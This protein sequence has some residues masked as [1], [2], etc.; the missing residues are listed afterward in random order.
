MSPKGLDSRR[1]HG[2]I[3]EAMNKTLAA[4]VFVG[5]AAGCAVT[6]PQNT[7]HPPKLLTD[8]ATGQAYYLYVPSKYNPL[9][10]MPVIVSCHG[11]DP[12]DVPARQIGEWKWMGEQHGCIIVCPRLSSTDGIFGSGPTDRLLADERV[13]MSILGQLQYMYNIDRRNMM[14]TGFSG[15]GFPTYFVGLRHPD[16]FS[17]VVGRACN[18]NQATLD[19]WYPDEAV[20]MPIFIYY[21]DADLGAI[22]GQSE[23]AIAY[24]RSAGFKVETQTLPGVGHQRHP[25]VAMRFFIKHWHGT[26]PKLVLP[27]NAM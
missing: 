8:P 13:I 26:A 6:Q 3:S 22:R 1:L 15:G 7:P 12:Y 19:G 10:P 25:E 16:I 11:T 2:R 9:R 21:G 4:M 17:V 23:N 14:I 18:F 27:P 20:K 5:L 24:F